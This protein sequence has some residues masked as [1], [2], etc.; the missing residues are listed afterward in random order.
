MKKKAMVIGLGPEYNY[1]NELAKWGK[2]NTRYAS[3]HGASLISRAITKQ[4]NAEFVDDFSN[5]ESLNNK[6]DTCF[7]AFATHITTKRDVSEYADV[8][9][10]L[11]MKVIAL[12]L[13]V[14]DY[15][16]NSNESFIFHPS[17]M[18]LLKIVS[19]KSNYIGVRGSHTASLLYKNGFTNVL[20]I[21]CPTLFWNLKPELNI[22]KSET[23]KEP[24]IVYHRTI[25]NEGFHLLKNIPIVG[26]DFLDEVVFTKNL[27]EDVKLKELEIVEYKKYHHTD[28][29]LSYI[30]KNGVFHYSFQEWFDYIR[31]KD[32]ILGPRLH[33]CI[34]ALIQGIPAVM[35]ARDLRVNEIAE[36]FNIPKIRYDEL[37][38]KSSAQQIFDEADYIKFN[39]TYKLRYKNYLNFLAL[40]G[41]ESNLSS[42]N[43][44]ISNY[45]FTQ[46]DYIRNLS[47]I[48]KEIRSLENRISEIQGDVKKLNKLKPTIEKLIK[49]RRKLPF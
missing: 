10:K 43:S 41:V 48:H 12:S 33:G 34:A 19:E 32:F 16:S 14:Q 1:P 13:G 23:F 36:F 18:K 26:Q 7:I 20:P 44:E 45:T 22:E 21:G 30:D 27:E 15:F 47:I 3:N 25:A 6:Y 11:D 46:D 49:I 31:T 38:D 2:E 9:E 24:A 28:E 40:N 29:I 37:S 39:E 4:F 8:I 42:N 35:L 5:I 17:L